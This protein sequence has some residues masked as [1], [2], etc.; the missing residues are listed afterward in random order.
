MF[1][2]LILNTKKGTLPGAFSKLFACRLVVTKCRK[3]SGFCVS[4]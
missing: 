4:V 3:R 1:N 2:L